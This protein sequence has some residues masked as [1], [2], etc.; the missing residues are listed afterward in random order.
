MQKVPWGL[1]VPFC[2]VFLL[3]WAVPLGQGF[4]LSLQSDTL[5]G[6]SH[7][8]GLSHYIRLLQ[9]TRFFHAL[10]NTAVYS[11][12]VL[13]TVLP[14]SL[15]L[16]QLLKKQTVSQYSKRASHSTQKK[17]WKG[18]VTFCLL[19]PGLAPPTILAFVFLLIFI[20]EHGILNNILLKPW[21]LPMV[22]WLKNPAYIKIALILQALW[23]W[24]GFI[25]L[26]L[27]S[28]MESVPK[29]YYEIARLEGSSSW[30]TF[31]KVTLPSIKH[32]LLFIGAFLILDSF[33]LFEG[34]YVLLGNSGGSGDAGLLLVAYTYYTAFS[35]GQFSYA[36]AMSFMLLPILCSILALLFWYFP[37]QRKQSRKIYSSSQVQEETV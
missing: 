34:A 25:T 7:F 6:E 16:A 2:G 15:F 19:L 17:S 26:F 23:R 1:L 35:T 20:G 33:I 18:A 5:F 21:G 24:T 8:V 3:F 9:D 11:L 4:W 10:Y 29:T 37:R 27:L 36:A 31:W 12:G 30:N 14:L 22:D 32:V 13:A 28:A